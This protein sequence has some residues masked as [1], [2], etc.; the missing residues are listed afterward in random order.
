MPKF[1]KQHYEIVANILHSELE[2]IPSS[3]KDSLR[4][5]NNIKHKFETAFSADNI[6]FD[7]SKF[8]KAIALE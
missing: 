4:H 1:T 5:F 7:I 3:E 6:H 2:F 8:E